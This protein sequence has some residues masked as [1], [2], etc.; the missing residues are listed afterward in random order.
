MTGPSPLSTTSSLFVIDF[1]NFD[2]ETS[3][4]SGPRIFSFWG[5]FIDASVTMQ[6]SLE[7][8]AASALRISFMQ[9]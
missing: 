4:P 3:S 1:G 5:W 7:I 2:N 8:R 6:R 9:S